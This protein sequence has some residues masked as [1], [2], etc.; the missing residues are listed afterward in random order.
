MN[1]QERA[2]QMGG[3]RMP[4]SLQAKL[5]AVSMARLLR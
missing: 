5:A 4:P 2:R 3:A 1:A